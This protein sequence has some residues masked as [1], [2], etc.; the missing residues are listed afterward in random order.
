MHKANILKDLAELYKDLGELVVAQQYCQQAL[1]L[2]TELNIPLATDCEILRQNLQ[3]SD[4]Y[5]AYP[6]LV[7]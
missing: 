2:A 3:E 6:A 5:S 7:Q 4:D 1:V